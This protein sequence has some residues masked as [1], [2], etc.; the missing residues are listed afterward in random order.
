[1]AGLFSFSGLG[2]IKFTKVINFQN[3]IQ[4]SVITS[5]KSYFILLTLN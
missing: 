2:K 1:M 3:V 5:K 4:K